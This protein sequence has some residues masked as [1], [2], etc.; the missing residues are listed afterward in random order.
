MKQVLCHISKILALFSR[1]DKVLFTLLFCLLFINALME[2][3]CL[4]AIPAFVLLL[5]K[6]D[7]ILNYPLVISFFE[8]LDVSDESRLFVSCC[9]LFAL[10]FFKNTFQCFTF[11]AQEY[12]KNTL[13]VKLRHNVFNAYM[14]APYEFHVHKNSAE[15]LIIRSKVALMFSSVASGTLSSS[16]L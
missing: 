15:V 5:T 9:L 10:F 7:I 11:Y 8:S 13:V 16:S 6:P 3:F 14:E 2:M 12:I 4:G 1:R